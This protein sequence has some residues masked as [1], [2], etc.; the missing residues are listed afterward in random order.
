VG[1][2]SPGAK[3]TTAKSQKFDGATFW[4]IFHQQFEAAAIQ[5]NWTPNDKAAHLL[6]VLQDQDA[7]TF[8]TVQVQMMYEDI[9]A[10]H[11][12]RFGDYKLAGP[13][14]LQLKARVQTSGEI[15]Q[16]SAAA[17][18]QQAHQALVGLPVT[19]IQTEA[20]H[21]FDGVRDQEVKQNLVMG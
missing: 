7:D 12:D 4:P 21:A 17:M 1:D 6:S 2:S 8:H 5:N 19:L 20:S 9:I 13:Y 11:R 10:A 16:E 18:E 15:L 3:T 14:R